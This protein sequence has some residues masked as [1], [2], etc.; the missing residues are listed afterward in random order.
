MPFDGYVSR[1]VRAGRLARA[2]A[3][4]NA[5]RSHIKPAR[6][7]VAQKQLA[8]RNRALWSA[9]YAHRLGC[10]TITQYGRDDDEE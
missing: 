3:L 8:R 4:A 5:E 9:D 6:L 7:T 10:A 2:A 1:F